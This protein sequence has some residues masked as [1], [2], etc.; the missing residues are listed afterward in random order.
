MRRNQSRKARGGFTLVEVLVVMAILVLL[1]GLIGPRVFKAQG[2][3]N[4]KA[5]AT[6][7][8]SFKGALD[9]YKVDMGDYPTTEQGL[10]ALVEE[11]ET[12]DE[13]DASNWNGPYL[14]SDD[15][16][17]DPWGNSYQYEYP[18][19]HGKGENPDI[20]SYGPDKEDDTEDD[21]V[22]WKKS[23]ED[24]GADYAD[25]DMGDSSSASDRGGDEE[26]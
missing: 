2:S 12:E 10:A 25:E 21:I 9:L 22:S 20:W 15:L 19:T 4:L 6:Q 1:F 16:P 7:V 3:A 26:R 14:G 17:K 24:E 11:P 18:P 8:K 5:A 13:S 23:A